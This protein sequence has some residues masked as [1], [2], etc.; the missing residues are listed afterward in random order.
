MPNRVR[1]SFMPRVPKLQDEEEYDLMETGSEADTEASISAEDNEGADGRKMGPNNMGSSA[2]NNEQWKK[3]SKS[4]R[5]NQLT[6]KLGT[7][8]KRNAGSITIAA[9]KLRLGGHVYGLG[10][11]RPV[12]DKVGTSNGSS[13]VP[14]DGNV[15]L[16]TLQEE[17]RG[18]CEKINELTRKNNELIQK[19]ED[20]QREE[21]K[22]RI[23]F[24]QTILQMFGK[25]SRSSD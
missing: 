12:L 18:A 16:I 24:K 9:Q 19:M 6:L 7:I 21:E 4:D 20:G 23:E 2:W 15:A 8:T 17:F 5:D 11:R 14:L 22:K 10:L 25:R 3:K 1:W 13:F